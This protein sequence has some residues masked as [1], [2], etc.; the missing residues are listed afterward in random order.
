[1][2]DSK[3]LCNSVGFLCVYRCDTILNL[4]AC[5]LFDSNGKFCGSYAN[6][7]AFHND[8]LGKLTLILDVLFYWGRFTDL[9][10]TF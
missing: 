2:P 3:P 10:G 9:I 7:R 5:L 4:H 8:H 1:M 6:Q